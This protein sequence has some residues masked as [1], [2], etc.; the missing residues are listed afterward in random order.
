MLTRPLAVQ[1][2]AAVA[3]MQRRNLN[4]TSSVSILHT[5]SEPRHRV[6]HGKA[7]TVHV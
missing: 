3:D 1:I 7:T 6:G 4:V 2:V 5:V